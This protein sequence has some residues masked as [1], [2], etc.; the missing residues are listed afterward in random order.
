MIAMGHF[1]IREP[2]TYL[3]P[4]E[5]VS[6]LLFTR[7][8]PANTLLCKKSTLL[9]DQRPWAWMQW[10]T[11]LICLPPNS[12]VIRPH[13]LARRSWR[14]PYRCWWLANSLAAEPLVLWQGLVSAVHVYWR[15]KAWLTVEAQWKVMFP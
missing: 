13:T 8:N 15:A 7:I 10:R 2:V 4:P 12:P 3:H 5:R 6:S 14:A 11:R 1:S 9:R